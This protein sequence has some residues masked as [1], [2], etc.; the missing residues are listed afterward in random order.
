MEDKTL[1]KLK[2]V[3]SYFIG[4]G[5]FFSVGLLI[6]FNLGATDGE[7]IFLYYYVLLIILFPLVSTM[8]ALG[9][10]IIY[11]VRWDR[12][13]KSCWEVVKSSAVLT[14]GFDLADCADY[15]YAGKRTFVVMNQSGRVLFYMR[16]GDKRMLHNTTISLSKDFK[17]RYVYNVQDAKFLH[18][19]P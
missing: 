2:L 13:M 12:V 16:P 10:L 5:F 17:D 1:R 11:W 8:C 15:T 4:C 18:V 3:V 19:D 7:P 14:L 9:L 6:G